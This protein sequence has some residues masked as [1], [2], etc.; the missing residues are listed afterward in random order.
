M[1]REPATKSVGFAKAG[2]NG[3]LMPGNSATAGA[4]ADAFLNKYGAM[5]G[6]SQGTIVRDSV[7]DDG[8]GGT[9]VTYLQ[10]YRGVPVFG[11]MLRA[12][13]DKQ[14]DLTAVNGTAVR[15]I[16]VS[17]QPKLS[18][19]QI[20]QRAVAYVKSDPPSHDG[21]K[22]DTTGI[23]AVKSD[24]VVY[25]EG[26]VRG[27]T[28]DSH[29]AYVVEVSNRH[30]IR[31]VVILTAQSG[32]VLNRYSLV[33][34]A[35]ER[36]LHE[37]R[38]GRVVWREG[39]RFP[40]NLTEDQQNIVRATGESYWF[41]KNAFNW[42]SYDNAGHIME[43]V[44]NDPRIS[45]P[46]ANWNGL[47]TN[48][49]NGVT[50]DDVVAHEWGHA[51]TDYT[52]DLIYQWQ[53]GAL[54]ESYSDIWGET[55]DLINGRMDADEGN[56]KAKRADGV[57]SEHS[58]PLARLIINSPADIAKICQ[59][60]SASFGPAVTSAGTTGDVVLGT[61][62]PLDS[63]GVGTTDGC[64]ALT[65][66]T[67]VA[68][69]VALLDRGNCAFTIKAKNAQNAGAIA[70]VIGNNVEAVS[71]MSG[72]DPTITIPSVLIKLSD[73][74][75]IVD[76]LTAGEAVNVTMRD[77]TGAE[78]SPSYRWLIGEDS[79]AFGGAIRDMWTPTCHGD[80]GKV[81]DAEYYCA[82]DDGGGVHSNSGVPNHGYALLVDGGNYNGY[83]IRAI[84][85]TKAAHIYWRAQTEYQT[86]TTD[87][88]DHAN[89]LQA[90]CADLT[91]TG[92]NGLSTA[93]SPEDTDP[94]TELPDE[95]I[96]A[97]N[98]AQV[99]KVIEAIE[100]RTEPTQCNFQPQLQPGDPPACAGATTVWS[101]NF[102]GG[103]AGWTP[104]AEWVFDP[105]TYN[106]SADSTLPSGRTGTAAYGPDPDAGNCSSGG[107][108]VS[109][110]MYLTSGNIVVNDV[111]S[112]VVL[113]FDHYVATEA[114]WDG[115]N[116]KVSVDGGG[117][118]VIPASA[119][120]FNKPGQI[121]TAAAGN[122]N[123]LAGQ[124]GF[125]GTDGG[126]LGGSWGTSQ[127]D[128]DQVGVTAGS[129]IQIRLDMGLDG[130]SGVDGWY[131]DDLEIQ[132]CPAGVQPGSGTRES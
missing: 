97:A 91:G 51:Y 43:S 83:K 74:N 82:A 99:G 71:G 101:E 13:L 116:V 30:N 115:G 50:S 20:G 89:A 80:P 132:V 10:E 55:V 29:L 23:R 85:L 127:I 31:D 107:G 58:P 113:N 106:W 120:T 35:L 69:H 72:V 12:H 117:F 126:E 65:N 28:G 11:A 125:T 32:K 108:D 90:S 24:L 102:E 21:H 22:A 62:A 95:T 41:F 93:G 39:K 42:D 100:L 27:V 98:C 53:S 36:R 40:R 61:D 87:F 26:I 70:A 123:P 37:E 114:G 96:T 57:C 92:V 46:N 63:T 119:Y 8:L 88:T 19:S 33:H 130:C 4:K 68:G 45:C 66:P 104:S 103:T 14:G 9:T 73:R 131:V 124:P 48:Y 38:Y 1:A 18:A 79:L 56:I 110:A 5:F 128:L 15:D 84:G 75:L 54:N 59:T 34:D 44:N 25:R 118:Q 60:G 64:T 47:T 109:G 86:P 6:A 78:K 2:R 81:S 16:N 76:K 52:H 111:G 17:V 3:D 94:P 77:V 121:N 112:N 49:C 67:E 129:T 7:R 105:Q 122:T